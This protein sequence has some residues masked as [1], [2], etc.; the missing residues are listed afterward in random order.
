MFRATV[1]AGMAVATACAAFG[2]SAA[3]PLNFEVAS[4]KQAAPPLD[5]RLMIRTAGLQQRQPESHD[6]AGL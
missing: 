2:Q 3:A 6:P 4:I 5:G 1:V